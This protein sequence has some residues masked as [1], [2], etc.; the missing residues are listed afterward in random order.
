[1]L[2]EQPDAAMIG[3]VDE[4]IAGQH[5]EL[6]AAASV[7]APE[8]GSESVEDAA[9]VVKSVLERREISVESLN[10]V[11]PPPKRKRK[12]ATSAAAAKGEEGA[13]ASTSKKK[14]G[15]KSKKGGEGN[16]E[17]DLKGDLEVHRVTAR[18]LKLT[19]LPQPPLSVPRLSYNLDRCLFK[20]GVY[21]MQDTR[22]KVYNFDPYL[23]TIM[24]IDQFDF[25]ALKAFVSSSE[26]AQLIELAAK[27]KKK[28]SGSTSSMSSMLAHFHY[29]LSAWRPI[30]P[31][32]TSKEFVPE[33]TNFTRILRAPAATFLHWKNGIYAIDADKQFDTA[34]ILSMMGK[35]M[36]KLFTVPKEEYELFRRSKSDQL[37]EEQRNG[38]EAFH[39]TTL[40]DFILRSQLDAHDPRL[41]Q[42]GMFDIKTRAV[43]A[44]RMDAYDYHKGLGY[45]I[46][47]RLGQ[48]ESF[49][50]EY[51]DM[52]RSAFLKYSLQVRMGR[53]DG[54]FVAYHN[55][56]RI[57]GFQYIPIEEMDLAIHGTNTVHLGD[58]EFRLSVHLLNE[59]LNRATEKFPNQSLRIHVEARPTN[60]PLLYFFARPVADDRIHHAQSMRRA[61]VDKFEKQMMGMAQRQADVEEEDEFEAGFDAESDEPR[62]SDGMSLAVWTEM[63]LKAE[64]AV[65]SDELGVGYVRRSIEEALEQSGLVEGKT[66]EEVQAYVETLL[67]I[68][69]DDVTAEQ[70]TSTAEE[71][72]GSVEEDVVDEEERAMAQSVSETFGPAQPEPAVSEPVP[73]SLVAEESSPVEK[74]TS[75]SPEADPTSAEDRITVEEDTAAAE[76]EEAA[77]VESHRKVTLKDLIMRLAEQVDD[78]PALSPEEESMFAE[79]QTSKPTKLQTFERVL[80]QL[81]VESGDE[82]GD[83]S[84][85][86]TTS[87]SDSTDAAAD[88]ADADTTTTT[89][90]PDSPSTSSSSSIDSPTTDTTSPPPTDEAAAAVAAL[91]EAEAE[92]EAEFDVEDPSEDLL[93]MILT[94]RNKVNGKYVT[95]PSS[96]TTTDRWS[97]EYSVRTMSEDR[98]KK[99]YALVKA[100]RR[101]A[102]MNTEDERDKQWHVMFGRALPRLS[103]AGSDFRRRLEKQTK[104]KP[105][106][107]VDRKEALEWEEVFGD[108]AGKE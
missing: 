107:F 102:L 56:Q 58:Q 4:Y 99:L 97:V 86:E 61:E 85:K 10:G 18:S 96:L 16:A 5:D 90:S 28:Y 7:A 82:G 67:E 91:A 78:R 25:S 1:M 87:A 65:K 71:E 39:Y 51:Y 33:S 49:E 32:N 37:T 2:S 75:E 79:Q 27:N 64:E 46:R 60:P 98:A 93:G 38:E 55:T 84:T 11:E 8:D 17:G 6:A 77:A 81:L 41:P 53:M 13:S 31:A 95:R 48:F 40:G 14:P 104:G 80:V 45:E 21:P 26:D 57:F 68:L 36:E 30:N 103:K 94:I 105:V 100:R 76:A 106:W 62:Y 12:K 72:Q 69:T 47:H 66:P 19:P 59:L 15:R 43:L 34:N 29:L 35:S 22:S 74:A 42:A 20:P 44:I 92:A 89:S 3:G 23:A 70:E 54:I 83:K 9:G 50:R 52:I 88:A 24:P 108:E 73:E 101:R 63:N